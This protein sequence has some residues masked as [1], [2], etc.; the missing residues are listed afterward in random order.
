MTVLVGGTPYSS[1]YSC[2]SEATFVAIGMCLLLLRSSERFSKT[3]LTII[4]LEYVNHL[5]RTVTLQGFHDP[6]GSYLMRNIVAPTF[7]CYGDV[8]IV[9]DDSLQKRRGPFGDGVR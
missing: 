7:G 8:V 2:T 9:T 1:F 6:N 3:T 4:K 5:F